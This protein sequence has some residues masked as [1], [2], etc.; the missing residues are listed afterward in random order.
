MLTKDNKQ[1]VAV[2]QSNNIL[3]AT[4]SSGEIVNLK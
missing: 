1:C 4:D 3:Q 2:S